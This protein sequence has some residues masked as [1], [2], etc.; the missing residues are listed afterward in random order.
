MPIVVMGRSTWSL[1]ALIALG[2]AI[3]AFIMLLIGG[4]SLFALTVMVLALAV[5]VLIG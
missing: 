5:A 3:A 2:V 4:A 1:G